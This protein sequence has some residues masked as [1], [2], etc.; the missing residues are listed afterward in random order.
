MNYVDIVNLVFGIWTTIW[1][2]M[3]VHFVVL[4]VIG[5]FAK[6][7]YPAAKVKH[8]YGVIIPAR[9][10][11][12][13]IGNLIKSVQK[14]DYPQDKLQIFV[15]A[16]NCTDD[17]A[18]IARDLG[19]TVYEY[20]NPEERTM[21]YALRYLFDQIRNDYGV[22]KF[23][24][25]LMFNADNILRK[26]YIEKMNDA[27]DA[28]NGQSV[29]LSFRNSKNFG[30]NL[31]SG[32][33]SM[34]FLNG[35]IMEARGRSAVGCSTHVQGTGYVFNAKLVAEGWPYVTITEDWEFS[36]D[37]IIKGT[38]IEYCDEAEFF[39]EQPT[40]FKVMWRQRVRWSRGH[41]LAC[42]SRFKDVLKSLFS[43]K[44]EHRN[45]G[46]LYDFLVIYVLPVVLINIGMNVL[47][48]ICLLL[49]P[50]FGC[51]MWPAVLGW[52]LGLGK[53]CLA[54]YLFMLV[55]CVII[56]VVERKRIYGLSFG[57]KILIALLWPFFIALQYVIDVVA[58]CSHNLQWKT[59]PHQ[60]QS[61]FEKLNGMLGE[62]PAAT[63][64][65]EVTDNPEAPTT[66][67]TAV[68]ATKEE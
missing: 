64:P 19:A 43:P 32:L 46:S 37:Q 27:F 52:L 59:I 39:D 5:L 57:R 61:D 50:L 9:N 66:T 63:E 28:T 49:A 36:A 41:I 30:T 33:S 3:M 68:A 18:K 20:N 54:Y 14:N 31:L 25:F 53:M 42:G 34:Y 40:S 22:E 60:D 10:E 7:R 26:N 11:A 67:T 35:C 51:A 13:V 6:K 47:Q 29:I 45:K 65:A 44:K 8:R 2:L 56:F 58:L 12:M 24:G 55:S 48:L 21:G 15:V 62:Q 4:T 17:T 38:K 1:G 16:H 23:D